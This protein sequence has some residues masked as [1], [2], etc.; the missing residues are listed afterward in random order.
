MRKEITRL[1]PWENLQDK[2]TQG[3]RLS[4]QVRLEVERKRQQKEGYVQPRR[5]RHKEK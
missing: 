1:L 4:S 5:F 2:K 3:G